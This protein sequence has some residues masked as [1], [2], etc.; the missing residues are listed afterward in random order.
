MAC[1]KCFIHSTTHVKGYHVNMYSE[2]IA[3]FKSSNFPFAWEKTACPLFIKSFSF[4]ENREFSIK[5]LL[6]EPKTQNC[7]NDSQSPSVI[8]IPFCG[9]L[10]FNVFVQVAL[11]VLGKFLSRTAFIESLHKRRRSI[12]RESIS[13]RSIP[14]R[15]V[16]FREF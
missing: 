1:I 14:F 16:T 3:C 12:L 8:R 6:K 10:S 4:H 2:R 13:H 15:V 5:I 11:H 9:A 7:I